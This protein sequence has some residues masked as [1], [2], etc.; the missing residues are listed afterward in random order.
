MNQPNNFL[1][2][3]I[4][5]VLEDL[6]ARKVPLPELRSKLADAPG[7][8]D[9]HAA[10]NSQRLSL[11]AEVKRSSPS[12]G[13]LA[14]IPDPGKLALNYQVGGADVISVLTESR[15]FGGSI[16]DLQSVRAMVD[17]PVLRKDFIV[18]EYQVIE[19]RVLGTDL[20]LLIVAGLTDLQLKDFYQLATELGM[21]VLIE[22]HNQSEIER[23]LLVEPK[24]IGI[25]S[26]NLKTLELDFSAFARLTPLIPAGIIKVAESGISNSSQVQEI[27]ALGMQ[28]ILVGETLVTSEADDHGI[29]TLMGRSSNV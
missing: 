19:S 20:M 7:V 10:L 8:R 16:Q 29:Q 15:R 26:R 6:Q 5:G 4:E 27:V 21:N 14:Q 11:I 24:I 25:N 22:I 3:I 1:G 28:A 17:L 2:S 13:V 23:A 12:K 18:T 9:A